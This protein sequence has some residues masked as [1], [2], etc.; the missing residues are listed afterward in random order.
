MIYSQEIQKI[1][2]G[3]NPYFEEIQNDERCGI[4]WLHSKNRLIRKYGWSCPTS[5]AL[6][7]IEKNA[8][9]SH[10]IEP[11]AGNG[12]WAAMLKHRNFKVYACDIGSSW[13]IND[14]TEEIFNYS[15]PKKHFTKIDCEDAILYVRDTC[16]MLKQF[17]LTLLMVWP[18]DFDL[19]CVDS[20]C[21]AEFTGN[22]A[23][24]VLNRCAGT[25]EL[26]EMFT[27][28]D[29][30]TTTP[31]LCVNT[32]AIPNKFSI[33]NDVMFC[34]IKH[35]HYNKIAKTNDLE[36]VIDISNAIV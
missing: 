33:N 4:P 3:E 5:Q 13:Y 10:I 27:N 23:F 9:G 15:N 32:V 11:F 24:I 6:N 2:N 17:S 1:S 12:Y 26:R 7:E 21:L 19:Y 30:D 14:V 20:K 36:C 35:P 28:D 25:S 22:T 29:K 18:N 8:V 31:W 16:R 34:L